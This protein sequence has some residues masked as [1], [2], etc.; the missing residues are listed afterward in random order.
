[1][2]VSRTSVHEKSRSRRR[3]GAT[4]AYFLGD[5][6][7]SVRQLTNARGAVTLAR[8]YQPYGSVMSSAGTGTTNYNFTG[9]WRDAGTNLLY[10]RARYYSFTQGRF[11]TADTWAGDYQR[12]LSL[13]KWNYVHGNPINS[14]DPTG[15]WCLFGTDVW[16]YNIDPCTPEDRK[17]A[18]QQAEAAAKVLRPVY[19]YIYDIGTNPRVVSALPPE[20]W[21]T[22]GKIVNFHNQQYAIVFS[23]RPL[24]ERFGACAFVGVE[25]T[26]IAAGV[27][28]V[29]EATISVVHRL[30]EDATGVRRGGEGNFD[31]SKYSPEM[32]EGLEVL[33]REAPDYYKALEDGRVRLTEVPGVGKAAGSLGRN[34][35][36]IAVSGNPD[37]PGSTATALYEEIDH[38]L[39]GDTNLTF[40]NELRAKESTAK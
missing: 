5:A 39:H 4:P 2:G 7:G 36:E 3:P 16:P 15:H 27:V 9:E 14:A 31:S 19:A 20:F 37:Y 8:S 35:G 32:Q 34:P 17:L 6:L 29:G 38:V 13:N 30:L 24:N 12:P 25:A 33:K 21:I 1:M 40:E 22:G 26:I 28:K 23:D 10:L 11:L 18:A